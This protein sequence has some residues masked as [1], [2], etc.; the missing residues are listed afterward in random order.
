[1]AQ[2]ARFR[3]ARVSRCRRIYGPWQLGH[4]LSGRFCF[5]LYIAQR[6]VDLEPSCHFASVP[7]RQAGYRDRKRLGTSL[8]GSFFLSC[9]YLLWVLCEIAICATDLAEVI[10]SAIA[11]NL[12][13]GLPLIWGVCITAFDV[14]IILYLQKLSFRYIEGLVFTLILIIAGCFWFEIF[15]SKPDLGSVLHGLIPQ[16]EILTNPEMLYI[17]IGILGATVMPHNLYLHSS[18]VQTRKYADDDKSRGAQLSL[19]RL[20]QR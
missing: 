16:P 15:I 7:L 10:G 6:C 8:Q 18:I 11:L 12:L 1:M 19:S 9:R 17:S 3:R 14:L 2:N 5:W 20:I 4:R 13:F